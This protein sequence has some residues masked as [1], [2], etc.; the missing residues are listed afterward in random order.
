V[1]TLDIRVVRSTVC[2]EYLYYYKSPAEVEKTVL[3]WH[4]FATRGKVGLVSWEELLF[5]EFVR[6]RATSGVSNV[7]YRSICWS[8]SAHWLKGAS[9]YRAESGELVPRPG[10]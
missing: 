9:S 6:S 7:L 3:A 4:A 2:E 8:N 10:R 5:I 1:T